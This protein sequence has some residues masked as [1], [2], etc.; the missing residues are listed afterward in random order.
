MPAACGEAH[1]PR[2]PPR[3][4]VR[5]CAEET[6]APRAEN[7]NRQVA[8]HRFDDGDTAIVVI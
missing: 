1:S 7:G 4:M 2:S 5:A 8:R 6:F 3:E